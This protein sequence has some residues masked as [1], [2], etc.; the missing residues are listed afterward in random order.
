MNTVT[1]RVGLLVAGLG[2]A[3]AAQAAEGDWVAR[4]RGTY[5]DFHNGQNSLPVTVKADSRWIPEV[6]F[7]YYLTDRVSTELVL[8]YPQKVDISVNGAAAGSVKALPPTLLA[9]YHFGEADGAFVPY[10]GAGVNLTLFS[11][12]SVLNGAAHISKTSVGP[13][14][15]AGADFALSGA[16]SLNVDLKYMLMHTNVYVGSTKAGKLDLDPWVASFGIGYRF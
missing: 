10:V 14:V 12:R 7:S 5:L 6:D 15:Q 11:S 8:T 3:A 13:T 16:W 4:V 1:K 2:I 9:Q